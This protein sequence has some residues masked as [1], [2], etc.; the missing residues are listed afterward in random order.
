MQQKPL[1]EIYPST[2]ASRDFRRLA[3]I[4]TT[5]EGSY[6]NKGRHAVLFSAINAT[7]K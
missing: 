6:T 7:K 1:I 4:I 3:Q 2:K 5:R